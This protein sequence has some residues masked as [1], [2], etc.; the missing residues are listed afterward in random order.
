MVLIMSPRR[1][2]HHNL[3]SI[4]CRRSFRKE[5]NENDEEHLAFYSISTLAVTLPLST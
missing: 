2:Q 4:H 5:V 3:H 1:I